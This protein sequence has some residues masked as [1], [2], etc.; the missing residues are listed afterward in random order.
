MRWRGFFG[1]FMSFLA[2][3]QNLKLRAEAAVDHALGAEVAEAVKDV[4]EEQTEYQVY[5][6]DASE[7]AMATRRVDQGGLGDRQLMTGH[8]EPGHE[9]V[10]ENIAPFQGTPV[11]YTTLNDVVER[12]TAGFNQPFPRPFVA[13]TQEEAISS[14]RARKALMEGLKRQGF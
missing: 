10:V 11:D 6:Y 4:M 8:V 2:H 9:L 7:M 13:G 1:D 3:Y 5:S 12:R 14:G